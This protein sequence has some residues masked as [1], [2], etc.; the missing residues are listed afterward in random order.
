MEG[1]GE[2]HRAMLST[3][4][5]TAVAAAALAVVIRSQVKRAAGRMKLTLS[6]RRRRLLV[7]R[8]VDAPDCISTSEAMVQLCAAIGCGVLPRATPRW[9]MKRRTGGTWEDLRVCDDANDDYFREK[10]HMSRRVT[11]YREP[12]QPEQIVEYALYRWATGET[13]DNS[14]SSFGIRASALLPVRDV[15]S[16]LLRVYADKISWPTGVW[17]HVVLRAFLEKGFSNYHGVVDCTHIYVDKPGNPPSENYFDHKHHFSVV[18]QI[19]VGLDQRVLDV[20]VGYPRSCHEIRVIQLF[21]LSRRAE[22]GTLFPGPPV[23]LL[24]GVRTNGYISG[25]N[26]YPPSEWVVVSYGGINQPPDEDRFN[27]KQKVTRGA[28]ERAFRRLKGMWRLFLRTHK[29]NLDTL[30]QQFTAVCILHNI[31]L[32][33]G[34]EFDEN[35]LREVDTNGVRR[36]VDLGIHL[37][38]QPVSNSTSTIKVIA[39]WNALA[40]RMKHVIRDTTWPF[41]AMKVPCSCPVPPSSIQSARFVGFHTRADGIMSSIAMCWTLLPS[42]TTCLAV[43]VIVDD[44]NEGVSFVDHRGGCL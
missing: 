10:L 31:L 28:V 5:K 38:P 27:K 3:T 12:L 11:F 18:T 30:L 7:K 16:A 29:T 36:R 14:L 41:L 43:L 17:K 23:M 44:G 32:D 1:D 22:E 2:G 42:R 25:D 37:P 20:F 4:E 34:I 35:L 40:E 21:S 13:Y 19:V 24:G 33:V 6:R 9:W 8:V 39:L 15:T 26:G